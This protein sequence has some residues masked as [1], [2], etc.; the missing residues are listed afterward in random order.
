MTAATVESYALLVRDLRHMAARSAPDL[1]DWIEYL[2]VAGK[3]GQTLYTYTRQI[4]PLLRANP[5]LSPE[6][7]TASH[8]NTELA[9]KPIQSRAYSRSIYNRWFSWLEDDERIPKSPMRRV[10][11]MRKQP[12]RPRDIFTAAEVAQLEALPSPD[13]PLLTLMF[14]TGMRKAECR[15]LRLEHVDL[16]R[17]RLIVVDG[18]GRKGR[19]IPLPD[20]ALRAVTDLMLLEG[21]NPHD[22][23][24]YATYGRGTAT[25]R[26]RRDPVASSTFDRWWGG[27][28]TGSGG[29]LHRAGVRYLNPHQSR[30][31]FGYRLRELG[32]DL[33]ERKV[34]MGHE[35]IET[36]E[37]YYGRVTIE[38]VAAKVAEVGV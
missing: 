19:V 15:H 9:Q 14:T 29:V 8:I 35:S 26:R 17:S 13:G 5:T 24:W 28:P 37:F 12:R 1:A 33:E 3:S 7:F 31:T 11:K 4:A 32:Y 30:H 2:Q 34:L 38:D 25:R 20:T 27:R 21:L 22:H 18:K 16:N 23:L 36:T 6:E 10:P